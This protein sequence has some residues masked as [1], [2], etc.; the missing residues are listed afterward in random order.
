[1][2]FKGIVTRKEQDT[3]ITLMSKVVT[4]N[5]KKST[6]K[7]F[8]VR[9]KANSLD[10]YSCCV[11]DHASTVSKLNSQDLSNLLSD[12]ALVYNGVNGTKIEYSVVDLG[13][14]KLSAYL[15]AD[16]KVNKQPKYGEEDAV[17]QITIKVIKGEALVS[18]SIPVTIKAKT[19][20]SVLFSEQVTKA[21]IWNA[22]KGQNDS[23]SENNIDSDGPSNIK[24]N[25]K[26]EQTYGVSTISTQPIQLTYVVEDNAI[27]IAKNSGFSSAELPGD[28]RMSE[29]GSIVQLSYAASYKLFTAL[30]GTEYKKTLINGSGVAGITALRRYRIG[31]IKV[32]VTAKLGESTR[33][34]DYDCCIVNKTLSGIEIVDAVVNQMCAF[35][36]SDLSK[37]KYVDNKDVSET[38]TL[39]PTSGTDTMGI[40]TYYTSGSELMKSDELGLQENEI[41]N[42]SISSKLLTF[43][44][45]QEIGTASSEYLRAVFNGG[46]TNDATGDT[47]KYQILKIDYQQMKDYVDASNPIGNKFCIETNIST[48]SY[49]NPASKTLYLKVTVDLKNVTSGDSA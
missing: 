42:V 15:T 33:V 18:S 29:D 39:T 3:G 24:S 28:S 9:V 7:N 1:M 34:F 26:F 43:D 25:L 30:I 32:T 48:S 41:T 21:G 12:L 4:P 36:T 16:G 37:L 19:E 11:I 23:M 17:G 47:D 22:I 14:P 8:L 49:G 46:I 31:G 10:D 40:R 45:A 6:K 2:S 44:G 27:P 20:D 35:R 13:A 38:Q 5:K